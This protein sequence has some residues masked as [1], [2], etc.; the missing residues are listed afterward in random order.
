MNVHRR[1]P[2][3]SL[4]DGQT[5]AYALSFHSHGSPLQGF[6]LGMFRVSVLSST[7]YGHKNSNPEEDVF[8]FNF[9]ISYYLYYCHG[10]L[11]L[12]LVLLA[13]LP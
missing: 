7:D 8:M 2:R 1:A 13:A 3:A 9:H 12:A 11:D 6:L 4:A 10:N 5:S